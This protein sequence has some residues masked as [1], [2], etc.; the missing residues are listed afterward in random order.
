MPLNYIFSTNRLVMAN[1][2]NIFL[3]IVLLSLPHTMQNLV[4]GADSSNPSSVVKGILL[5]KGISSDA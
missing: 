3:K 5:S 1:L 4:N 2:R